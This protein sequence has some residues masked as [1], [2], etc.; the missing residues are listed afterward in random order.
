MWTS[1]NILTG[2]FLPMDSTMVWNGQDFG[3]LAF[4][5]PRKDRILHHGT[6]RAIAISLHPVYFAW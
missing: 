6:A 1:A 5:H 2:N 3:H 4:Q